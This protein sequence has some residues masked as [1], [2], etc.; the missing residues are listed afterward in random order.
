MHKCVGYVAK[1]V[2]YRCRVLC[3]I[4]MLL[5]SSSTGRYTAPPHSM[6]RLPR[7]STTMGYPHILALVVGSSITGLLASLVL[8][9]YVLRRRFK[10]GTAKTHPS[11]PVGGLAKPA[12]RRDNRGSS[13]LAQRISLCGGAAEERSREFVCLTSRQVEDGRASDDGAVESRRATM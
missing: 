8:L 5:H 3:N 12:E 6:A 2:I 1:L 11:D 13:G 7:T 10:R 9:C 4:T